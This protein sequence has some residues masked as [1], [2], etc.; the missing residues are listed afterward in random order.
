[1]SH[2]RS[3]RVKKTHFI[4]SGYAY[5]YIRVEKTITSLSLLTYSILKE[6]QKQIQN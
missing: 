3:S 6:E 4:P 2:L 1:M 5:I